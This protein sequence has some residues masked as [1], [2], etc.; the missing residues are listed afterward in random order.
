MLQR[1]SPVQLQALSCLL[2]TKQHTD[3]L[4]LRTASAYC[5]PE[6]H[7][8]RRVLLAYN[9]H[10]YSK[11]CSESLRQKMLT[12]LRFSAS[13]PSTKSATTTCPLA[14]SSSK[15]RPIGR[16]RVTFKMSLSSVRLQ[17]SLSTSWRSPSSHAS[18]AKQG[19]M[20]ASIQED[21][22]ACT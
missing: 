21:M 22:R 12:L 7:L 5:K 4:C 17:I 11:H 20:A 8:S 1:C 2:I 14:L 10:L 6:R 9:R 15:T 16:G 19:S 13:E 3:G 18:K